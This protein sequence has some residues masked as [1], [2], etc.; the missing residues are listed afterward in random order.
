MILLTIRAPVFTWKK[1]NPRITPSPF[2]DGQGFETVAASICLVTNLGQSAKAGEA[3]SETV[4]TDSAPADAE[5]AGPA[6]PDLA[7]VIAVWP[8]LPADVRAGIMAMVQA[9]TSKT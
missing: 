9:A 7:R 3:E 5:L 8:T 2:A 6:D 1:P 4:C